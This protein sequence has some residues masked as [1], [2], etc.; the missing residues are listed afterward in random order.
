M[1]GVESRAQVLVIAATNR[2]DILD[3]ALLRPGR[4]DRL[5]YVPLPNLQ[6]REEILKIGCRKMQI[7]RDGIDFRGLAEA[8]E[9]LSGAELSL[10]CREAGLLALTENLSIETKDVSEIFVTQSHMHQALDGVKQRG[11]K[12]TASLFT[13]KPVL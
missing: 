10:V 1:D 3:S 5:V 11:K 6:G 7:S 2:L 13:N 9:G 12:Q 4:F 8:S